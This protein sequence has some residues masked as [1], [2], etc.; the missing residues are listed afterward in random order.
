[1]IFDVPSNPNDTMILCPF[2]AELRLPLAQCWEFCDTQGNTVNVQVQCTFSS[3]LLGFQ[4]GYGRNAF[5]C[6]LNKNPS[7]P[8]PFYPL[9]NYNPKKTELKGKLGSQ[10][11]KP[12]I[13]KFSLFLAE[14]TDKIHFPNFYACLV[15]TKQKTIQLLP[16]LQSCPICCS[17]T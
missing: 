13:G 6:C 1:M 8:L 7:D 11:M 15:K 12:D 2:S 9:C 3:F 4:K 10:G 16:R 17:K 5:N 14:V